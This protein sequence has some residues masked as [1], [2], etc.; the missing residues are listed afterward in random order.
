MTIEALKGATEVIENKVLRIMERARVAKDKDIP[1]VDFFREL[2]GEK[3]FDYWRRLYVGRG[4]MDDGNPDS[5]LRWHYMELYDGDGRKI[6]TYD[7]SDE[8]FMALPEDR[9]LAYAERESRRRT[10][11]LWVDWPGWRGLPKEE[12]EAMLAEDPMAPYVRV[13][14]PTEYFLMLYFPITHPNRGTIPAEYSRK[15]GQVFTILDALEKV[16]TDRGLH[17]QGILVTKSRRARFTTNMQVFQLNRLVN[18]ELKYACA[19]VMDAS[20]K[21][22]DIMVRIGDMYTE[23]PCWTRSYVT[24]FPMEKMAQ[25]KR[26]K[27]GE[28]SYNPS[29]EPPTISI[30]VKPVDGKSKYDNILCVTFGI[31][32]KLE[33]KGIAMLFIDEYG[34]YDDGQMVYERG[35]KILADGTNTRVGFCVVGGVTS[36][37]KSA[38]ETMR[39]MSENCEEYNLFHLFLG[40]HHFKYTDEST[41]W[42]DEQRCVEEVRNER[43]SWQEKGLRDKLRS[44]FLQDAI[45]PNDCFQ[46]TGMSQVD[47]WAIQTRIEEIRTG[48]ERGELV[49]QRGRFRENMDDYYNPIWVPDQANGPWYISEHPDAASRGNPREGPNMVYVAGSDN[50]NRNITEQGAAEINAGGGR[51]SLSCMVVGKVWGDDIVA[52]YR[53]RHADRR[54]DYLQMLLGSLYFNCKNLPEYNKEGQGDFI[55]DF[56][57]PEGAKGFFMPGAFRKWGL[58]VP[59]AY[60]SKSSI[61][62]HWIGADNS[63]PLKKQRYEQ[64]LLPFIA[65]KLMCIPFEQLLIPIS[66]WDIDNRRNTPDE[67]MAL[68]MQRV[69]ARW[70]QAKY[71]KPSEVAREQDE[72]KSERAWLMARRQFANWRRTETTLRQFR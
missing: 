22:K 42:A 56:K 8:Y 61:R 50:A 9:R 66:E 32:K 7:V 35:E 23:L 58:E 17:R 26:T 12:Q 49:I 18:N 29:G 48:I 71:K 6:G 54:K 20:D 34:L 72:A 16:K 39:Q 55:F 52:M 67:G 30:S 53:Y 14:S 63:G 60:R 65:E 3:K 68:L 15:T 51:H 64:D 31:P 2:Y 19:T 70:A 24:G 25:S 10:Y 45:H 44:S 59:V 57:P 21:L 4:R 41:G 43:K 28:W 62:A 69:A 38:L 37:N 1:V 11:G 13:F 27:Q 5:R 40:I 36:T 33:G 47:V 46:V